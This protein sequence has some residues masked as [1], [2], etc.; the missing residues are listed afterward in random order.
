MAGR[1]GRKA[2]L[3]AAATIGWILVV[4]QGTFGTVT[5]SRAGARIVRYGWNRSR[6]MHL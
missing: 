2:T 4:I 3:N 5:G 1:L 6:A